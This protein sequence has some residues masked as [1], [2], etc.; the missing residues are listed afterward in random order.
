MNSSGMSTIVRRGIRGSAMWLRG[1]GG[2]AMFP[3]AEGAGG[4]PTAGAATRRGRRGGRGERR[5][6]DTGGRYRSVNLLYYFQSF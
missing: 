1:S 4:A 3:H 6:H 5:R 2:G